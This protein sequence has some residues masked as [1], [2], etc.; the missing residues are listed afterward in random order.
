M[1]A[2]EYGAVIV[3]LKEPSDRTRND[4]VLLL[5]PHSHTSHPTH[6]GYTHVTPHSPWSHTR[7]CPINSRKS[8]S[9]EQKLNTEYHTDGEA[10]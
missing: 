4:V 7:H 2:E 5:L 10:F 6:P 9:V 1:T 8:S 3:T